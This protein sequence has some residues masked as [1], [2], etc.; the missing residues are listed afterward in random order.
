MNKTFTH[1]DEQGLDALIQRVSDAKE[2]GLAL[3]PEDTQLLLDALMTLA[4]LQERLQ[5]K[6]VTLHKLRK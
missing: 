3:S 5:D 4:H 1:L 2:H 6:D